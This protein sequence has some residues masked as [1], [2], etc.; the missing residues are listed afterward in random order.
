MINSGELYVV[1][2]DRKEI[3]GKT[4][5]SVTVFDRSIQINI[6]RNEI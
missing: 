2:I 4:A 5:L 3:I 6:K 1:D